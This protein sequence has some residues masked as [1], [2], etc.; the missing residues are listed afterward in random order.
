VLWLG[1]A[2]CSPV[3]VPCHTHIGEHKATLAG[4]TSPYTVTI[5][6]GCWSSDRCFPASTG[7]VTLP[8]SVEMVMPGDN[9]TA[10]FELITPVALEPGLRFAVREGSRTVAAGVVT[11]AM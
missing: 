5:H 8:E 4:T 9:V 1:S 11:Q 3:G 6:C 10:N 2:I 7:T